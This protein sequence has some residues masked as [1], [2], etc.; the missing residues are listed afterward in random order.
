VVLRGRTAEDAV[1][2]ASR[3]DADQCADKIL[4]AVL[5]WHDGATLTDDVTIIVVD[6]VLSAA[7][8]T[9][10]ERA[11][12]GWQHASAYQILPI[13][14]MASSERLQIRHHDA[15]AADTFSD[16]RRSGPFSMMILI[17]LSTS[18]SVSGTCPVHGQHGMPSQLNKPT[19]AS[20][21]MVAPGN[22]PPLPCAMRSSISLALGKVA[23]PTD[24]RVSLKLV[25]R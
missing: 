19:T 10:L 1:V 11:R 15:S 14:S 8:R 18:S 2:S 7:P 4:N 3:L 17:T 23:P 16:R 25:F 22:Q 21:S 12:A 24:R 13:V 20:H 9:A 5:E 6:V